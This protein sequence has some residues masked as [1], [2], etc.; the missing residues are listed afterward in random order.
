[1]T[2]CAGCNNPELV[3]TRLGGP[4][5]IEGYRLDSLLETSGNGQ[6]YRASQIAS[7]QPCIIRIFSSDANGE[8]LLEEAR[9]AARF[10]HENVLDVYEAGSLESGDVFVVSDAPV[11]RTLRQL[12]TDVGKPELLQSIDIIRQSAEALHA[13]H[14]GGST[15]GAVHPE[16]IILANDHEGRLIVRLQNPDFGGVIARS[17]I[18]NKF[19]I[20]SALD[21]LRY[22][23]PEQC[24]GTE[25]SLQTDVYSLGII[26]Y[27]LLAGVPP[28]DATKAVGLIEMHRNHRAPDI[29]IDNF[30]LRM[31]ITHSVME[32]LQKQPRLRQSSA[33]LLARQL[34]HIEQLA[35]HVSTPPPAAAVPA[36]SPIPATP[37]ET[38]D[39]S[40]PVIVRHSPDVTRRMET[41][42]EPTVT[43]RVTPRVDEVSEQSVSRIAIEP[44]IA[45]ASNEAITV[46]VGDIPESQETTAR[47]QNN[48][49][50]ATL[51]TLEPIYVASRSRLKLWK[52]KL[53]AMAARLTPEGSALV[54]SILEAGDSETSVQ[55]PVELAPFQA[56]S[57]D[58]DKPRPASDRRKVDWDTP[59]DDIP[60]QA[61]VHEVLAT[62]SVAPIFEPEP[63]AALDMIGTPAVE[64]PQPD[65]LHAP[66]VEE[67]RS[68]EQE[69]Q[70]AVSGVIELWREEQSET[71][72]LVKPSDAVIES[73][74]AQ[75]VESV[76]EGPVGQATAIP[77]ESIAVETAASIET[78]IISEAPTS[79]K[80]PSKVE[81]AEPKT[82]VTYAE[83]VI[84]ALGDPAVVESRSVAETP[85]VIET[86]P[87]IE[88][89]A[90]IESPALIDTPPVI[91]TRPVIVTETPVIETHSAIE[92]VAPEIPAVT[93]EAVAGGSPVLEVESPAA[94]EVPSADARIT[95]R[96]K[97]LRRK[98]SARKENASFPMP[99]VSGKD[100]L[101][102][103]AFAA[104]AAGG[105]TRAAADTPLNNKTR[106][107]ARQRSGLGFPV[108]LADM[109]EITIVRAPG[110][111]IKVDLERASVPP[112]F[113]SLPRVERPIASTREVA[114]SPTILGSVPERRIAE[115]SRKDQMF[116]AYDDSQETSESGRYHSVML[117]AGVLALIGLFL[118]GFG[119]VTRYFQTSTVADSVA[120][121]ETI[122]ESSSPMGT[123][124]PTAVVLPAK[125]SAARDSAKPVEETLR[126]MKTK[127]VAETA[128]NKDKSPRSADQRSTAS[129]SD[130][131]KTKPSDSKTSIS[132]SAKRATSPAPKDRPVTKP[133]FPASTRPRIVKNAPLQ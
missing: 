123:E 94:T 122:P 121:S 49:V 61:A 85:F 54:P 17:I 93:S 82:A 27:E 53:H 97:A 87:V 84:A 56:K 118:F 13:I 112:K 34:R 22:F 47:E 129:K 79:V 80:S 8:R 108:N 4:E 73:L 111:R 52:K 38:P 113:S 105:A 48:D 1:M 43:P 24:S 44:E 63:T 19:L 2:L 33:N 67:S 110:R 100:K 74:S 32:A 75:E 89:P 7:G 15:H 31:L 81:V 106:R 107:P 131:V 37:V 69:T 59:D 57:L 92:T 68:E 132:S 26:F 25:T 18:S 124:V 51:S 40:S 62:E 30:H 3:E 65:T 11:G 102:E 127:P 125:Q 117:V 133:A 104:A 14:L 109:E 9:A 6:T 95:R 60:S 28:F 83:M 23:A 70:S 16:N 20:D 21:K 101:G 64:I 128:S 90:I 5:D 88:I 42:D 96:A 36:W 66:L 130:G 55:T 86:P 39:V 35:T 115:P 120:S 12:L 46:A 10:F 91:E 114:F 98:K 29:R 116:S 119:S 126:A 76:D 72:V 103:P 41:L 78:P 45:P 71:P 77:V 99:V 50:I 58:I